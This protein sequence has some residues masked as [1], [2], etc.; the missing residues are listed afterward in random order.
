[1]S[2]AAPVAA[3]GPALSPQAAEFVVVAPQAVVRGGASKEA[4]AIGVLPLGSRLVSTAEAGGY[5]KVGYGTRGGFVSRGEVQEVA[6]PAAK[7]GTGGKTPL[8]H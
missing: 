5:L 7:P 6:A 3:T 4:P 1:M 2:G 8:P